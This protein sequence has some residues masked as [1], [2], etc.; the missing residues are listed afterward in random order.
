[1]DKQ[2]ANMLIALI[3]GVTKTKQYNQMSDPEKYIDEDGIKT[4]TNA[5]NALAKSSSS[6]DDYIA[7]HT[8]CSK[9]YYPYD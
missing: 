6:Q 7:G 5:I 9:G 1:M 2:T 3:K 4:L 8:Y